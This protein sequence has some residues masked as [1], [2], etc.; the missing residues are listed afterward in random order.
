MPVYA[1]SVGPRSRPSGTA[2]RCRAVPEGRQ[3]LGRRRAL[4][5]RS[6]PPSRRCETSAGP[7][8]CRS[9]TTQIATPSPRCNVTGNV[10]AVHSRGGRAGGWAGGL[11]RTGSISP[12]AAVA[13]AGFSAYYTHTHAYITR[14]HITHTRMRTLRMHIYTHIHACIQKHTCIEYWRNFRRCGKALYAETPQGS[15]ALRR[16]EGHWVRKAAVA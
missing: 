16:R 8:E 11:E 3:G 7:C 5:G 2:A 4:T 10:R 1:R 14:M 9:R 6:A 15:R 13:V 12:D